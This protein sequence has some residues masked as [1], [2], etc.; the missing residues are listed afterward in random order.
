[1][2]PKS[3]T[4]TFGSREFLIR[5]LVTRQIRELGDLL[6]SEEWKLKPAISGY[7]DVIAIGLSR[8]F[9]DDAA[10]LDDLE[11]TVPDLRVASAQLFTFGGFMEPVSGEVQAA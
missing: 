10:R 2:R 8:D 3:I 6:S 1:M 4:L 11:A 9:A 7:L 5:P